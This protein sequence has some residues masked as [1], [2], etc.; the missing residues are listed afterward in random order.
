[1]SDAPREV[2][3]P[4]SE[5]WLSDCQF[6]NTPL[7]KSFMRRHRDAARYRWLRDKAGMMFYRWVTFES[8][9]PIIRPWDVIE[10]DIDAAMQARP[11][12]QSSNAATSDT[13]GA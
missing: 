13:A 6:G 9:M 12:D 10:A 3:S 4:P 8:H 1:M 5:V 11:C 7:N 2:W